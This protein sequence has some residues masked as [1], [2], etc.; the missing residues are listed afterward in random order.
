M[1]LLDEVC[2]DADLKTDGMLYVSSNV[3]NQILARLLF[4][5]A[6]PEARNRL[7]NTLESQVSDTLENASRYLGQMYNEANG[8]L[9]PN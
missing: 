8:P 9:K 3:A 4:F 5:A 7:K 2:K 1:N 6:N